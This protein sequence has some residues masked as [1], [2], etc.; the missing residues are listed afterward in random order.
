MT[1]LQEAWGAA[2]AAR[3]ARR[4]RTPLLIRAVTW[5]GRTLPTWQRARTAVMQT[6]GLA[7][8]DWALYDWKGL[9]AG[10]AGAGV[11]LLI[12]EALGEKR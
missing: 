8:I 4:T 10:L 11:S 2:R 3:P 9:A 6:A 7:A 1:T 5:A 12:L